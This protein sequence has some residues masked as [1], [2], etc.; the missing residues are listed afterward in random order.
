MSRMPVSARLLLVVL[1]LALAPAPR[2]ASAQEVTLISPDGRIRLKGQLLSHDGETWRLKTRFGEMV[3]SSPGIT[4]KGHACPD[5]GQY[6]VDLTL[7]AP[8]GL[9]RGLLGA[10]IAD[11]AD[12]AGFVLE[13][14]AGS[15]GEAADGAG[16]APGTATLFLSNRDRVPVA[17]IAIAALPSEAALAA[18]EKRTADLVLVR[19][20]PGLPA[21]RASMQAVPVARDALVFLVA[22]DNPVR[23]LTRAQLAGILKGSITGW[24][25]LGGDDAAIALKGPAT[26]SAILKVARS[27]DGAGEDSGPGAAIAALADPEG[28][29]AAVAADPFALGIGSLAGVAPARALALRGPCGIRQPPSPFAVASGDYPLVMDITALTLRRRQPVF[30]RNFLSYL[31][32][33]RAARVVRGA[34]LVPARPAATF[35]AP[36]RP[37]PLADQQE[38]LANAIRLADGEEVTL[39]DLQDQVQLF[40]NAAR[41]AVTI[42]FEGGSSRPDAAGRRAIAALALA[43]E[44]GEFDGRI[45]TLAGFSDDR[46]DAAAN[47]RLSRDRAKAVE[48]ALRQQATRADFSAFDLRTVGLGEAAPVA[49]NDSKAGRYLNRRVEI[50]V[51]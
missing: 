24:A 37:R 15:T 21:P 6:A 17:R 44:T 30:L 11:Y 18:L 9:A 16:E 1:A 14:G 36:I 3:L 23:A 5:P 49:C 45:V 41:L 43:A 7:A 26:D 39:A 13:S 51:E 4:C 10:L 28:V 50:W 27:L 42:R 32:S 29:A 22:P 34:G 40:A 12:Y 38:R 19:R 25:A 46:G 33:A 2:P 35:A 31:R 47:R 20:G 8:P 48:R